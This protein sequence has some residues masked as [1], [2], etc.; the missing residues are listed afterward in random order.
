MNQLPQPAVASN[1]AIPRQA[2]TDDQLIAMWVAST[3]SAHARRARAA[4]S[5]S[6]LTHVGKPL[7]RVT[8]GDVISFAASFEGL[9]SATRARRLSHAKSLL[10]FAHRLGYV[11][12]NCG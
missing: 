10:S 3:A 8:A 1:P 6:F 12:F 5:Q 7:G 2:D 11:P 9:A 4:D